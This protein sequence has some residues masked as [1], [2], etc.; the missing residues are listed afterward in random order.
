MFVNFAVSDN[1]YKLKMSVSAIMQLEKKLNF[2]PVLIFGLDGKRIPTVA[3]MVDILHA[4]LQKYHHGI[5]LS[6]ATDLFE[7]WLDEGHTINDFLPVLVDIYRESGLI[8]KGQT[9]K[10]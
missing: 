10:N 5:T 9:E 8:D 6:K 3:E 7:N 4:S 1:E 2:N